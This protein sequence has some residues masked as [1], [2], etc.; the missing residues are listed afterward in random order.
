MPDEPAREN[1]HY[2]KLAEE[3]KAVRAGLEI[4]QGVLDEEAAKNDKLVEAL[5]DLRAVVKEHILPAA[6]KAGGQLWLV[7]AVTMEAVFERVDAAL[8]ETTP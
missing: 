2:L 3:L 4:T 8:K 7:E 5:T 1:R 6:N